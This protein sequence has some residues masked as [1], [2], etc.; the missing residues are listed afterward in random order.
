MKKNIRPIGSLH[1]RDK[2]FTLI[3][4]LVVITVLGLL[5]AI[6]L[7][8]I[9]S[10]REAA[11]RTQCANNLKQFG[12]A[13]HSYLSS[14]NTLHRGGNSLNGYSLHV[15]FLPDMDNAVLYNSIN[16]S[17]NVLASLGEQNRTAYSSRLKVF[18][19]PSDGYATADISPL[20]GWTNYAGCIGDQIRPSDP[21]SFAIKGIFGSTSSISLGDIGDGL[22]STVAISEF[23][24]GGPTFLEKLRSIFI[25]GDFA[26]GPA[27]PAKQFRDRCF[28]LKDEIPNKNTFKGSIWMMG[29]SEYTLYDNTFLMNTPSCHNTAA[30]TEIT[31]TVPASSLHPGG[32]NVL[33]ADGHCKFLR[34]S[35]DENTWRALGTRNQGEIIQATEY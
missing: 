34:E 10:A 4:V 1:R 15:G 27:Y 26:G 18:T 13:M 12:L 9:Q 23:L 11:R 22:S 8:A 31:A 33:F 24:V 3:E 14:Y 25:P 7:P 30:S 29:Q 28:S 32:V 17:V 21:K 5:T 16:L 2:A 19:C 20:F 6:L 35:M